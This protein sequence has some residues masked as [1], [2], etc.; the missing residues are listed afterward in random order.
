MPPKYQKLIVQF[1]DIQKDF[2]L[3]PLTTF[4]IGGPAD[5]YYKLS[6]LNELSALVELATSLAIP[7]IVLGGGSNVVFAD[8]GFRGLIIQIKANQIAIEPSK[9]EKFG[10]ISAE[11]GALTSQIIQFALK[12][13]LSG[14]EKLLGLPGTIGGAVR[15]NA[16]AYGQEIRNIFEKALILTSKNTLKEAKKDYFSFGYRDSVVK[17]NKNIILKVYLKLEKKDCSQ[18]LKEAA[19]IL[20]QRA[21]KQPSGCTAGSF[22]KNPGKDLSAGY[23]LEQSG[24]KGLQIGQAQV[25]PKHANWIMNL[26]NA[27]QKDILELAKIMRE[28]VKNRFN[29]TLEPEVQLI[30]EQGF[31][32]N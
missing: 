5:L 16:G 27:T 20:K 6:D 11:A 24:C 28:R 8:R 26:G 4:Q 7:F 10:I 23:L 3:A 12:N 31:I 9:S 17:K 13:N 30:G 32:S 21:G 15:G 29:I 19:E 25:S 14:L 22:F 2:P 1:P 18:G